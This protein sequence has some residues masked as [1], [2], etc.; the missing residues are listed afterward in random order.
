MDSR[1]PPIAT[2][3]LSV[4]ICFAAVAI[5]IKPLEQRRSMVTPGTVAGRPA[6]NAACRAMARPAIAVDPHH[7]DV[8]S[9]DRLALFQNLRAFVD[10]RIDAALQNLFVRNLPHIGAAFGTK[11]FNDLRGDG[12]WLGVALLVV[13]VEPGD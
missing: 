2:A 10:H 5:A 11:I 4:M 1:P 12:R 8:G 13:V 7:V 3:M 6:R 9:A